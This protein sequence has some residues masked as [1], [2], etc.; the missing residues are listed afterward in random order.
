MPE[1][2]PDLLIQAFRRL[3]AQGWKLAVV[4]G[5]SETPSFQAKLL[6]LADHDPDI[7]FT[8]VLKGRY[9]AEVMRGAGLFVL[10][11]EIEGLPLAMLEAMQE[12]LPIVASN[13]APHRQLLGES[14]GLTFRA[15]D[16][17]DCISKLSWA[18]S[19]SQQMQAMAQQAQIYVREHY[20]W[21]RVVGDSFQLHSTLLGLPKAA[22]PVT[23]SE[24]QGII[25][26]KNKVS[27]PGG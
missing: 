9:L 27:I 18:M 15:C 20:S 12:G 22:L 4:G 24:P 21:E 6:A 25:A 5:S 23:T 1:K 17:D 13:I 7:L 10:P 19:N 3:Q 14:R 8:G 16:L 26:Q 11:S 2:C